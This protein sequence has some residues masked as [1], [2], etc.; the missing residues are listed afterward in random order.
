MRPVI[1]APLLAAALA[2]CTNDEGMDGVARAAAWPLGAASPTGPPVDCIEQARIRGHVVRD[3]RTIDFAMDDGSLLRNSLPFSCP[4]L[5]PTS[6]FSY[7]TALPRLCSTDQITL[8][9]TDG[10]SGGNCGLGRFQPIAI[11]P[12][13]T[14]Q[15]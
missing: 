5:T 12:V 15:R 2:G 4:A 13:E 7:R 3:D 9:R 1:F 14:P 6:R 11:P 8:I 10:R